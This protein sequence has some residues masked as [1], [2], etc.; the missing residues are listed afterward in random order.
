MARAKKTTTKTASKAKRQPSAARIAKEAAQ[1][2]AVS[3]VTKLV[4]ATK[5]E[6]V[7]AAF[8][9]QGYLVIRNPHRAGGPFATRKAASSK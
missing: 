9:K 4:G 8:A 1:Q 3:I 5:A 7:F 6:G 2:K